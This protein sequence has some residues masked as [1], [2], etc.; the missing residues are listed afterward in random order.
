MADEERKTSTRTKSEAPTA[1][2]LVQSE[3][4]SLKA[5]YQQLQQQMQ[6]TQLQLQALLGK[7]QTADEVL[8]YAKRV[9]TRLEE[10]KRSGGKYAWR[11]LDK[12]FSDG[13]GNPV[14]HVIWSNARDAKEALDDFRR[15]AQVSWDVSE[16]RAP[17][18]A[19]PAVDTQ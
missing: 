12:R 14:S 5:D 8:N 4:A 1:N 6:N 7:S 10:K 16:H 15:R 3:L 17:Y 9:L 2:D 11:I 18:E 19:E 13:K